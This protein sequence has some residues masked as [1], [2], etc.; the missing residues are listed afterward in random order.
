MN[1]RRN[2]LNTSTNT[3]TLE[4]KVMMAGLTSGTPDH[5]N[6]ASRTASPASLAITKRARGILQAHAAFANKLAKK[7]GFKSFTAFSSALK[8]QGKDSFQETNKFIAQR[9]QKA[10]KSSYGFLLDYSQK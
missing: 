5:A 6:D 4:P 9:A 8:S 10:G 3:A 7:S 2:S 1:T